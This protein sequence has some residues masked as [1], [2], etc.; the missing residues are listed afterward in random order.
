MVDTVN[1]ISEATAAVAAAEAS[2]L[3]ADVNT[4]QAL[5]TSLPDC[6][7]KT[8]LQGRLDAVQDIIDEAAQPVENTQAVAAAKSAVSSANYTMQQADVTDEASVKTAVETTISG[9]SLDGVGTAVTK[10]LYTP[11]IAGTQQDADGT[12]GTYTFTVALLKG[13]DAT[14]VTDTTDTLTMTITATAYIQQHST[15]Q[16]SCDVSNETFV[17]G[18]PTGTVVPVTIQPLVTNELG[19]S[20]VRFNVAV[21]TK[22]DGSTVNLLAT[23]INSQEFDVAAI[24]YWGPSEGFPIDED[25]TATTNFT[26]KFDTAGSYSIKFDLVD[27]S[28]NSNILATQTVSITVDAADTT[29]PTL[30]GVTPAE[31]AVILGA[32]ENFVFTVDASDEGGLYELE[33]DHNMTEAPYN[34]PEF[35]VYANAANPYGTDDDRTQFTAMGVEVT[36]DEVNQKWTIDFG[37]TATEAFVQKGNVTFYIVVKD[38]AGNQFGTMYGT[39]P[40]NTFAYTVSRAQPTRLC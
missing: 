20:N 31:G 21:I 38:I 13:A 4:A 25:Y 26:A 19:Y 2:E 36:Y 22:P 30:N 11:A 35:S 6:A 33:I 34:L 9:L 18:N 28:N 7:E 15:Y 1:D 17:A 40:E 12:N 23:D 14:L 5:V 29:S 3:Q 16:F 10:V 37:P 39:T 27:I 24:G 8:A 32:D